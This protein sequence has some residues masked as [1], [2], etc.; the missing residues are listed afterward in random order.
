LL[1]AA[2]LRGRSRTDD[3]NERWR[4]AGLRHD[5]LSRPTSVTRR[6][7]P[8]GSP[9]PIHVNA[10]SARRDRCFVAPAFPEFY[11]TSLRTSAVNGPQ[12]YH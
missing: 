1:K 8:A 10:D 2:R 3:A 9:G 5:S 11:N 4:Q 7:A 12:L 6:R